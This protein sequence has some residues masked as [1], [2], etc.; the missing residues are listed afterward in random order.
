[1]YVRINLKLIFVSK[2]GPGIFHFLTDYILF[3]NSDFIMSTMASQITSL[4]IVYSA[5][6]SSVHSGADH[7]KHQSSASLACV[8]GIHRWPV[9][10]PPPPPP[11]PPHKGPV[12]RKCFHLVTSSCKFWRIHLL[13]SVQIDLMVSAMTS[14]K[15]NGFSLTAMSWIC[16]TKFVYMSATA[17]Q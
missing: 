5:V 1:M 16:W 9:N 17:V 7:R 15:K 3:H 12:T 8:R 13:N 11:P 10:A 14:L 2:M 4:A 6:N